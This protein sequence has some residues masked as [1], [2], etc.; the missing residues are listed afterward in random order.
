LIRETLVFSSPEEFWIRRKTI[1]TWLFR[2][3]GLDPLPDLTTELVGRV[4]KVFKVRQSL[5]ETM[6]FVSDSMDKDRE[7]KKNTRKKWI[8][9]SLAPLILAACILIVYP[10]LVK[11]DPAVLFERYRSSLPAD[12]LN[13]D[14]T[15]YN[16]SRYYQAMVLFGTD[17]L[18]TAKSLLDELI[19]EGTEYQTTARWF[20]SLIL[21]R[22]GKLAPCREQLKLI[23][24][25]DPAF[26][27]VHGANLLKDLTN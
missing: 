11:P 7:K 23:R 14:T 22:E 6:A 5:I 26:F 12:T 17:D 4:L 3:A 13:I 8:S 10:I 20:E 16:A 24:E 19:L 1:I 25:E 9:L 21:L 15:N 2:S 18:A 27:K